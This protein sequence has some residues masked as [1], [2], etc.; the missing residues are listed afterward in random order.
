VACAPASLRERLL[1]CRALPLSLTLLPFVNRPVI[2]GR[3]QRDATGR[4]TRANS[5]FGNGGHLGSNVGN[6][7]ASCRQ[8]KRRGLHFSAGDSLCTKSMTES[9]LRKLHG[10]TPQSR[11]G[12]DFRNGIAHRPHPT[13]P[14]QTYTRIG[15]A[16]NLRGSTAYHARSADGR[17][18][19]GPQR[20]RVPI[21][22]RRAAAADA[23]DFVLGFMSMYPSASTGGASRAWQVDLSRRAAIRGS[24]DVCEGVD[25]PRPRVANALHPASSCCRFQRPRKVEQI[26]SHVEVGATCCLWP[27]DGWTA[28]SVPRDR[29]SSAVRGK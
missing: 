18:R 3:A 17:V 15:H 22:R 12:S 29:E 8:R 2:P 7:R 10:R 13:A 23:C 4:V 5:D 26:A 20:R 6:E 25:K 11:N 1:A 14:P 19:V 21:G 24:A 27:S 28:G 16:A 9:K